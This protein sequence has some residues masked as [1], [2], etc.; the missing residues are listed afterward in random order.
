MKTPDWP[1]AFEHP[2]KS[3]PKRWGC[4]FPATKFW[5]VKTL[6]KYCNICHTQSK[7]KTFQEPEAIFPYWK[8]RKTK[9]PAPPIFRSY[10]HEFTFQER[11]NNNTSGFLSKKKTYHENLLHLLQFV[12]QTN[13]QA[14]VVEELKY[15]V[16]RSVPRRGRRA[17]RDLVSLG[18]GDLRMCQR[19]GE[20]EVGEAN[21]MLD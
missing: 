15:V 8:R 5:N 18:A 3:Q 19:G 4:K 17:N 16:Q 11:S 6:V 9:H 20:L 14:A 7:T 2:S 12:F 1:T 10:G 13:N 21:Q